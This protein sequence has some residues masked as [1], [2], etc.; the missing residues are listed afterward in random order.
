[1]RGNVRAVGL[2]SNYGTIF[3]IRTPLV[4]FVGQNGTNRYWRLYPSIER[5]FYSRDIKLWS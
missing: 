1:V 5:D 3:I 4:W 2:A